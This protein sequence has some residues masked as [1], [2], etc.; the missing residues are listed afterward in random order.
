MVAGPFILLFSFIV[1]PFWLFVQLF[2]DPTDKDD[3]L[4]GEQNLTAK[5]M[6]LF[7]EVCN[8]IIA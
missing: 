7:E 1:D 2:N 8:D 3:P 6:S 4:K 5:G